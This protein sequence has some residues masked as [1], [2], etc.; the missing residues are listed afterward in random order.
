MVL[1]QPKPV[2]FATGLVVMLHRGCQMSNMLSA[3]LETSELPVKA[4]YHILHFT[5][6]WYC[7][8]MYLQ[9][10]E[11]LEQW[12]ESAYIYCRCQHL[13]Y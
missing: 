3:L 11:T 2:T 8:P 10:M 1:L 7:L 9:N 4:S 12:L 6:S 13:Q 5:S